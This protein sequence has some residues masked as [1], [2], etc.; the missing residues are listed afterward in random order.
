MVVMLRIPS[1]EEAFCLLGL[2]GKV[3]TATC[4]PSNIQQVLAGAEAD[5]LTEAQDEEI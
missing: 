3:A 4:E 2:S 5:T 1:G